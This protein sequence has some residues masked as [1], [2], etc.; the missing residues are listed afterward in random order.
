MTT[1]PLNHP[2]TRPIIA[3]T[4]GDACGVGPEVVFKA[5]ARA[6]VRAACR[7]VV[8]GA[9]P[10]IKLTRDQFAPSVKL[11]RITEFAQAEFPADAVEC[12]DMQNLVPAD[13][14]RGQLS[15]KAGKAAAEFAIRAGELALQKKVDAIATAPLNKEAMRMG[16][17][18]YIGHTEL[19]Q[20]LAGNPPVATMLIS[21]ELRVVHVVQH[22][23]LAESLRRITRE[24][25]VYTIRAT[26]AGMKQL[27]FTQPRLGVCGLNPH[28]GE[29]GLMGHEEIDIIAPAV[30]IAQQEGIAASG[31]FAADSIF[32]RAVRGEYDCIVAMLHDQGHIAIKTYGFDRSITVTLG[33]PFVRTSADHG[34]AFDIA[35][36]G[37][38]NETSMAEAIM[39]AARL[40]QSKPG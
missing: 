8:I 11:R 16:G 12:L 18:H 14:P 33:L 22:A 7:P 2:T 34:T 36:K 10:I 37:I 21:G 24:N 39:L 25:V 1:Q 20:E 27:G 5:L 15:P 9:M 38:A 13:A 17:V 4:I 29:G 40:A 28:N 31:P 32:F 6:D 35:G 30:Q 3:I 19:Y 23:S 26:D